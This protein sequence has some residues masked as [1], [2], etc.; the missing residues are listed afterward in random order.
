[1][2]RRLNLALY[3]QHVQIVQDNAAAASLMATAPEDRQRQNAIVKE[4]VRALAATGHRLGLDLTRQQ[5][6][7]VYEAAL[8][9]AR[10]ATSDDVRQRQETVARRAHR[11]L[12]FANAGANFRVDDLLQGIFEPE[13]DA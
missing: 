10:A 12:G 8:V 7:V 3:R 13:K 11:A 2:G 6:Q 1:M 9:G 4:T 5:V